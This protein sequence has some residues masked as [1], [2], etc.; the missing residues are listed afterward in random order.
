MTSIPIASDDSQPREWSIG[1]RTLIVSAGSQ[2]ALAV[3][4]ARSP[5]LLPPGSVLQFDGT[6]G[7]LVVTRVRVIA[8]QLGGI[9]CAEVEPARPGRGATAHQRPGDRTAER[10]RHLWPASGP[11]SAARAVTPEGRREHFLAIQSPGALNAVLRHLVKP[12]AAGP[13]A[14]RFRFSAAS[15]PP[16]AL[17]RR[18]L[19]GRAGFR[20]SPVSPARP[21]AQGA[22]DPAPANPAGLTGEAAAGAGSPARSPAG[23]AG[24]GRGGRGGPVL[25]RRRARAGPRRAAPAAAVTAAGGQPP[26]DHGQARGEYQPRRRHDQVVAGQRCLL[27]MR[28]GVP[29][30]RPAASGSGVQPA[31]RACGDAKPSQAAGLKVPGPRLPGPGRPRRQ[32]ERG[33]GSIARL[34]FPDA[35]PSAGRREDH[36]GRPVGSWPDSHEVGRRG[37]CQPGRHSPAAAASIWPPQTARTA[38]ISARYHQDKG[39]ARSSGRPGQARRTG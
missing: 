16:A 29:A 6:P 18:F 31:W 10:L 20:C 4:N 30:I 17:P 39:L 35:P 34:R 23:R 33:R 36:R 14:Q 1:N 3:L 38:A 21:V 5:L 8:G 15:S 25:V 28:G 12:D 7:E 22:P 11:A 9:V 32:G 19:A 2:R 26:A 27:R 13:P 37:S 24:S